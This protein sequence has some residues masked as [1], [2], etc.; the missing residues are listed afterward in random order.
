MVESVKKK[1]LEISKEI[2]EKIETPF[3]ITDF[4]DSESNY[5]KLKDVKNIQ[6]KK[7]LIDEL[8]FSNLKT[9]GFE[10]T[11]NFYKKMIKLLLEMKYLEILL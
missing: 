5:I 4:D 6:L 11:Y 8:G 3:Q 10:P 9:N 7:C 1:F 2:L